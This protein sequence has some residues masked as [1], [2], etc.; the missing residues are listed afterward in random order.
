MPDTLSA[1]LP[2]RVDLDKPAAMTPLREPLCTE[3]HQAYGIRVIPQ[4]GGATVSLAGCGAVGYMIRADGATVTTPAAQGT[5]EGVTLWLPEACYAVP[6]RFSL[7]VKLTDSQT[8]RTVLWL[9]GSVA[10]SRTDA[11][12]DPEHV[13]PS[14]DALLQQIA[15][16]EEATAAAQAAT[17][18]ATGAASL[19]QSAAGTASNAAAAANTAAQTAN[20]AAASI[21]GMTA[22]ASALPAG[23]APT[24][25]V[26]DG[27]NG[28]VVALGIPDGAKGDPGVTPALSIGTVTTGSPGTN[29]EATLTGTAEAPVLNLTI[30]RGQTG[31]V[32]N[33]PLENNAPQPLGKA[34]PGDSDTA[35]RGD[36][37]HEIPSAAQLG[38]ASA[39]RT[40]NGYMLYDDIVLTAAAI[41]VA[42]PYDTLDVY[43]ALTRRD[44]VYNLLDNSD[45]TAPVNQRGQS[46][47]TANGY[48]ID[49]WSIW[50]GA[51]AVADGYVSVKEA[52]QVL[53]LDLSKTYTLAARTAEGI[54]AVSGVF[55]QGG[56]E[57]SLGNLKIKMA[58][59]NGKAEVILTNNDGHDIGGV[60]WAA[61]YEG[62]YT[63]DTLPAYLPKGYAAELLEC[64]RYYLRLSQGAGQP[65]AFG[66]TYGTGNGRMKIPTPVAMRIAPTITVGKGVDNLRVICDGTQYVGTGIGGVQAKADGVLCQV[67]ATELP[68][69]HAATLMFA[70][71]DVLELNAEL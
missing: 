69:A 54:V 28:K 71:E 7:I 30:P 11:I 55:G 18:A 68:S 48:T 29:A 13:V 4:R 46:T 63:A 52:Y 49:R 2:Y 38:A 31:S 59:I 40:I 42:A 35:A 16:M 23:S 66:G 43:T 12:V 20:T 47:Y 37:V 8:R 10:R 32:E 5:A 65:L 39:S 64:Q 14:L 53:E 36:H 33:L 3:D 70:T 45:F 26:T 24:V 15:V 50:A 21:D 19:A 17:G 62:A 27:E 9:E 1:L 22:T 44:R 25:S 6:G 60:I 34:S 51:L 56:P 57:A 61:L 58:T 67:T 41:P